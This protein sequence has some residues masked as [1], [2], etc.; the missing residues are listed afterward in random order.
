MGFVG[1]IL[2]SRRSSG[3]VTEHRVLLFIF[4]FESLIFHDDR[5]L[6]RQTLEI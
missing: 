6:V 1:V 4:G 5:G 3:G 2:R